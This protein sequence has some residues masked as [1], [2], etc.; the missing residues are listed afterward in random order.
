MNRFDHIVIAAPD[1]A[2]AKLEFEELTGVPPADGG[3]HIGLGTRNALVSFG[4]DCYLEIIAPDPEQTLVGTFGARLAQLDALTL[5]HWAVRTRPKGCVWRMLF[6]CCASS[7]AKIAVI[8]PA[9]CAMTSM[10]KAD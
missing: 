9:G 4:A 6:V 10:P 3:P 7:P 2:Q 8:S 1:L 5:L